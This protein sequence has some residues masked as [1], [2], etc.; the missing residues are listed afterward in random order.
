MP[1]PLLLLM[2]VLTLMLVPLPL[3]LLL[4]V[5][6][7]MLVGHCH[8]RSRTR[9]LL[10]GGARWMPVKRRLVA[11]GLPALPVGGKH[12]DEGAIT[13]KK[14]VMAKPKNGQEWEQ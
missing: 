9:L 5:L 11:M 10:S 3:L 12:A 7:L 1:L 4:L 2:L 14:N 6:T 13:H 8:S